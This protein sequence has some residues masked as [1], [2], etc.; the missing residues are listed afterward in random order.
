M[1][2]AIGMAPLHYLQHR[3]AGPLTTKRM[4]TIDDDI[5][6]RGAAFIEQ[7]V[8]AGKPIFAWSG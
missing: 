6:A 5:A 4:E 1:P 2:I 7:Q 8:K 3:H